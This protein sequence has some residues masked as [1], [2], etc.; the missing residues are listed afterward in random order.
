MRESRSN[1]D[2]SFFLFQ[3]TKFALSAQGT[4]WPIQPSSGDLKYITRVLLAILKH[5][6]IWQCIS[7]LT[8]KWMEEAGIRMRIF[9]MEGK[10]DYE[11]E[12][13]S[14]YKIEILTS[15]N[16]WVWHWLKKKRW[17]I[18]DWVT[19]INWCQSLLSDSQ[20]DIMLSCLK[21]LWT[22]CARVWINCG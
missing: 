9:K 3:N 12:H 1:S 7:A 2:A 16:F 10:L 4:L 20:M 15:A 14:Q 13:L 5:F 17:E 22:L 6:F 11:H 19:L 18:L 8:R 21:V